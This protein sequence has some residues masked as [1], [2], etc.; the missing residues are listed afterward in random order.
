[1]VVCIL[2][3]RRMAAK[4]QKMSVKASTM[5]RYVTLLYVFVSAIIT[6]QNI[7]IPLNLIEL[8]N[9]SICT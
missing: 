1:M 3:F 2:D 8:L 7:E 5:A 9:S 4:T 6:V